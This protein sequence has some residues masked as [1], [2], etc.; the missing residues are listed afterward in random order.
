MPTWLSIL[1]GAVPGIA[2]LAAIAVAWGRLGQRVKVLEEQMRSLTDV[3]AQL[4]TIEERTRNTKDM[5]Q[6]M[7]HKMGEFLVALLTDARAFREAAV[8]VARR[9]R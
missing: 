2:A 8:A 1:I 4:A 5:V 6:A 3:P 9:E 7:D